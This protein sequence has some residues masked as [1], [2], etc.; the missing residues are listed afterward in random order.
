M[1][2]DSYPGFA[3]LT[4]TPALPQLALPG[5]KIDTVCLHGCFKLTVGQFGWSNQR[6]GHFCVMLA[7]I[8]PNIDTISTFPPQV[9]GFFASPGATSD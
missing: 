2:N 6:T 8:S 7:Y 4:Q 3:Q 9:V 5:V 1:W